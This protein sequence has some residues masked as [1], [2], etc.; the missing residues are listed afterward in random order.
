MQIEVKIDKSCPEPKVIIVSDSMSDEVSAILKK[1]SEGP[2]RLVTITGFRQDEAILLE[3]ANIVR[4]Y[5]ANSK[6]FAQTTD[7]REYTI[8]RRLY[9]L[10]ELL[11]KCMFVRISNSE[12]VNL[13]NVSG[14]DLSLAGTICVRMVNGQV[15]YVSRRYVSGIRRVLG[16]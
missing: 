16:I 12:I 5:A 15:T 4:I 7:N 3:P 9:E 10:E 14:F 2:P 11:N 1:L 13:K 8:R 6:V